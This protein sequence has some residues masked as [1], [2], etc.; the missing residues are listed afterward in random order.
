MKHLKDYAFSLAAAHEII[1]S[2]SAMFDL[3]HLYEILNH[4]YKHSFRTILEVTEK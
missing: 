3:M 2:S 4:V 1:K